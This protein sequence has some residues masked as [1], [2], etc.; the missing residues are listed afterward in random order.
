MACARCHDHKF[1]ALSAADYT[2]LVGVMQSSRRTY[3]VDDPQ[4]KL[5]AHNQRLRQ[6]VDQTVTAAA[7]SND[8]LKVS[9]QALRD[10]L[11]QMIQRVRAK[12]DDMA[13]SIVPG[14]HGLF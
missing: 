3:A 10:W 6:A 2:S 8:G 14:N 7:Q 1:D 13:K 11:E 5:T 9:E 4:G 12:P